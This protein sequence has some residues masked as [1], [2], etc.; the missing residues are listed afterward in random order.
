SEFADCSTTN[1]TFKHAISP[2]L[3]GYK[4]GTLHSRL[5]RLFLK[6][7]DC[8]TVSV[9]G[10]RSV[11]VGIGTDKGQQLMK[12]FVFTPKRA[13]LLPCT[14]RFGWSTLTCSAQGFRVSQAG[15]PKEATYMAVVLGVVR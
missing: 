5:M 12:N 10:K 7:K 1:K 3:L 13:D 4:D 11:F 6:I 14:Y 9:R 8:D 15:F 2:F